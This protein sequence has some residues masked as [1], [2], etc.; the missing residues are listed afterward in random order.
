MC[1]LLDVEEDNL[2]LGLFGDFPGTV[3]DDGGGAGGDTGLVTIDK[4]FFSFG[5]EGLGLDGGE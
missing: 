2:L 3:G 4:L 1:L 5:V